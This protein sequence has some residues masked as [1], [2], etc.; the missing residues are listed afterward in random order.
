M[1][2]LS[3]I[4]WLVVI[5]VDALVAVNSPLIAFVLLT[6]VAVSY[7]IVESNNEVNKP[8]IQLYNE[9]VPDTKNPTVELDGGYT[10]QEL[11]AMADYL[12]YLVKQQKI[13]EGKI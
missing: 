1:K 9:Y 6:S 10:P 11:R 7:R 13:K 3:I 12:E 2:T 8:D 4:G 5:I